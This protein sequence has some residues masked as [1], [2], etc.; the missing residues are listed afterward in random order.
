MNGG[1]FATAR[2]TELSAVIS[3]LKS[4]FFIFKLLCIIKGNTLILYH[5]SGF[6]FVSLELCKNS[7]YFSAFCLEIRAEWRL[8]SLI[9]QQIQ[10][11]N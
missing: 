11:Q 7:F 1:R 2:L 4:R 6:F 9:Y 8:K 10:S 5:L 3:D